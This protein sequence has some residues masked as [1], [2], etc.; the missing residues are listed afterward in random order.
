MALKITKNHLNQIQGFADSLFGDRT[1]VKA[2]VRTDGVQRSMNLYI[3]ADKDHDFEESHLL[4][5]IYGCDV[6]L[7][8]GKSIIEFA[9]YERNIDHF[10]VEFS[11][12]NNKLS[13]TRM[14]KYLT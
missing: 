13:I 11:A 10:Q 3:F 4:S 6:S 12:N 7:L 2:C 9:Y 14:E 1:V 8:D 5:S